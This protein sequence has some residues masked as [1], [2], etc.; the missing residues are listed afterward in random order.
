[1]RRSVFP[2]FDEHLG[3]LQDWDVWLTL[4]ERGVTGIYIP[5]ILYTKH[6]RPGDISL[7]DNYR[8]WREI[9]SRKH[10]AAFRA[11]RNDSFFCPVCERTVASFLPGGPRLRPGARCPHCGSL[12]RHRLSWLYFQH[13]TTVLE[14]RCAF[15]HIAPEPSILRRFLAMSYIHY[16]PADLHPRHPSVHRMDISAISH[17][18]NSFDFIYASHVLE[19][20][21]DD[22]GAIREFHRVLKPGGVA[23]I[24]V[25]IAG[26][27]TTEG[28]ITMQ[29][30]ER[31]RMFGQEDHLRQYGADFADR[32]REVG[33]DVTCEAFAATLSDQEI[34]RY[35]LR[36]DEHIYLCTK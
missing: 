3:R 4:L 28:G 10:H 5:R 26:T 18:N 15:L 20:V 19:H 12:E 25:P 6:Y 36:R 31:L 7:R 32:L 11:P 1:M 24:M 34:L 13:K 30:P 14:Q 16:V 21:A 27:R 2:G 35:G 23:I 9:V 29:P 17:P 22:R 8:Q 33:W